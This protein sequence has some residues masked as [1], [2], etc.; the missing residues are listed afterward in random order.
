MYGES[1]NE[2]GLKIQEIEKKIK[3]L[4]EKS[5][6]NQIKQIIELHTFDIC[7][8]CKHVLTDTNPQ[9]EFVDNWYCRKCKKEISGDNYLMVIDKILKE[10]K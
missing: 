9:G 7:P 5:I 1:I 8:T 2:L 6:L 3:E 10:E 4:E